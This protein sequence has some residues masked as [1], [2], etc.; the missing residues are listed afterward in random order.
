MPRNDTKF[1]WELVELGG[2]SM[3]KFSSEMRIQFEFI[4]LG[5]ADRPYDRLRMLNS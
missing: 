5:K 4:A 3:N 1:S 2:L